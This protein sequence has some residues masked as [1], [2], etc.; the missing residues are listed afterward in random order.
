MMYSV[1]RN[2]SRE[3]NPVR[4][5]N[6][7]C[8]ELFRLVLKGQFVRFLRTNISLYDLLCTDKK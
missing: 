1:I 7:V 3:Q 6:D 2:D 5:G 4:P 8:N